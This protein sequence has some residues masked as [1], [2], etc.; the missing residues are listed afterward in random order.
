LTSRY[1]S[2]PTYSGSSGLSIYVTYIASFVNKITTITTTIIEQTYGVRRPKESLIAA[3]LSLS[4]LIQ[5]HSFVL[6]WKFW[7]RLLCVV[8]FLSC[9][10]PLLVSIF[11]FLIPCCIVT[12]ELLCTYIDTCAKLVKFSI[13]KVSS[14]EN[15]CFH[16]LDHQWCRNSEHCRNACIEHEFDDGQCRNRYK[17]ISGAVCECYPKVCNY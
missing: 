12:L 2:L 9:S 8:Y 3:F 11:A 10:L 7:E 1:F 6:Q 16:N 13:G 17:R 5:L 4:R 15:N 14:T